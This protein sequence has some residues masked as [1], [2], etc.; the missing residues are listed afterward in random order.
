MNVH[1]S[2]DKPAGF[3]L[4]RFGAGGR[5]MTGLCPLPFDGLGGQSFWEPKLT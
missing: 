2:E 3:L 5:L 4:H 1:E